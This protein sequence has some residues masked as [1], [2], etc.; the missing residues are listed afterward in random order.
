M[1]ATG[2]GANALAQVPDGLGDTRDRVV[3]L[4][5]DIELEEL[6]VVIERAIDRGIAG[7]G[8]LAQQFREL[9]FQEGETLVVSPRKARV[10]LQPQ[11]A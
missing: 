6:P 11:T 2:A 5:L 8:F 9:G 7:G 4:N 3:G 1:L 10:F